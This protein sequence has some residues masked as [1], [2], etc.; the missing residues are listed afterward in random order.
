[1]INFGKLQV[2]INE[3][4]S[5]VGI[6]NKNSQLIFHV[7][8]GFSDDEP[9]IHTFDFKRDLFFKLYRVLDIF[10]QT[11]LE[12]EHSFQ[13]IKASDRDGIIQEEE[14][15]EIDGENKQEI[16]F[17]KLDA[18]EKILD[19][20]DELKILALVSRL[21][22]TE[23]LDY[24]KLHRFL[25]KGIFLE[26]G[27]VYVDSMVLS[28]KEVRFEVT[29]IINMYC[30]ILVEI[31]QQLEQEVSSEVKALAEQFR[32]KYIGSESSLFNEAS[33]E[34]I[35]NDLKDAL[36]VIDN[37]TP[38]R[39]PDYW[40]FYDAIETFLFG[41][42]DYSKEGQVWGINNFHSVWEA[43][44][45]THLVRNIN[46]NLL[47]YVDEKLLCYK[48][49]EK[50]TKNNHIIDIHNIFFVND[51]EMF[52]DAII[53]SCDNTKKILMEILFSKYNQTT[54]EYKIKKDNWDDYSYLT[55]FY[56]ELIDEKIKITYPKQSLRDHT[57]N[58]LSKIF[59]TE[60]D[61]VIIT[62][63]PDNYYSYWDID[64]DKLN[65]EQIQMMRCFNHV[66][67]VAWKNGILEAEKFFEKI[68]SSSSVFRYS[69]FRHLS[70]DEL[71][72]LY[73]ELLNFIF[74]EL[75]FYFHVIDVKYS[76]FDYYLNSR[77]KEEIK[78]RSVRKQ[79]LYEYLI[80]KH[81]EYSDSLLK[82]WDIKSDFWLPTYSQNLSVLN[83]GPKYLDGYIKLT[84]VNIMAVIDSYLNSE[85]INAVAQG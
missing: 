23:K 54:I 52:P 5:F 51:C 53:I 74:T 15:A 7:P 41:G 84:G 34:Q 75:Q 68:S 16:N 57:F 79:F 38:I 21:G 4:Y 14:G 62:Y 46:P 18:L 76:Q 22:K 58:E 45:L 19:A 56:S 50:Y 31:K 65:I 67:Y 44:C 28:R 17:S 20:Y 37:N 25:H 9:S 78:R 40:Y 49:I 6:E 13:E 59:P 83:E 29:D 72:Y 12:K 42:L 39:D 24:S 26:N 64:I 60:G 80:Q 69:I 35:I 81:L 48:D 61:S 8:K 10:K 70:S 3:K 27:A 55:S 11:L 33:Y 43:I 82:K 47:L 30:Y 63:L 71:Q 73:R 85:V 2:R 66:F 1:M 32:Q 36:E 77:N